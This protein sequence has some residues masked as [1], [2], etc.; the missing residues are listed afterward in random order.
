M[1]TG[2]TS[3][4]EWGH[5]A[6]T[7]WSVCVLTCI[8]PASTVV[9]AATCTLYRS[10][11][12]MSTSPVTL[13]PLLIRK[14]ASGA[15]LSVTL[16]TI[17]LRTVNVPANT[18]VCVANVRTEYKEQNVY[19]IVAKNILRLLWFTLIQ[20]WNYFIYTEIKLSLVNIHFIMSF[21]NTILHALL[22]S[23]FWVDL[24]HSKMLWI[25]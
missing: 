22:V 10:L 8:N 20:Q 15:S 7:V 12:V 13:V 1:Y 16:P 23:Q 11:A 24:I 9:A 18:E 2:V 4:C 5:C 14:S 19:C 25:K 6:S 17:I 3:E 21:H